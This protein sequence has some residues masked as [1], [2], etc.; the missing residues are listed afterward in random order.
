M[1]QLNQ[2]GG[3]GEPGIDR[4]GERVAFA[5]R[6]RC[7]REAADIGDAMLMARWS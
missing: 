4:Q 6:H 7:E 5:W 2:T 3:R 1:Q